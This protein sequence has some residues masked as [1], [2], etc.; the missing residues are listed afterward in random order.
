MSQMLFETTKL[1]YY[2][3]SSD[4]IYEVTLE[5]IPLSNNWK[6][7]FKYGKRGSTLKEG[8]KTENPVSYNT[9]RR[10][11]NDLIYS[12]KKKG[13]ELQNPE[14]IK[15]KRKNI[16]L[17]FLQKLLLKEVIT[18][19]EYSRLKGMV[20][21]PDPETINLAETIILNKDQ[22]VWELA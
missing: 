13:Y 18:D 5:K 10:I 15:Q 22:N 17:K 7:T 1:W 4:K 2:Q 16:H 11:Y 19:V 14:D 6:V 12:K 9:A 8:E 3:G 21:S 20:S